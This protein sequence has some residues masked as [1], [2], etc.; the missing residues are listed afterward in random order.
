[1]YALAILLALQGDI[2]LRLEW[3]EPV[4]SITQESKPTLKAAVQAYMA[5]GGQIAYVQGKSDR[6]HLIEDHGWSAAQLTGLTQSE[7]MYLHGATHNGKISPT[8]YQV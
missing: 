3:D 2:T 5:A 1:M 6:A 4:V 8:D 7:L